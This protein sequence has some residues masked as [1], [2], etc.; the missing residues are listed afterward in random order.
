MYLNT[1]SPID[2]DCIL[3]NFINISLG[4]NIAGNVLIEEN[5]ELVLGVSKKI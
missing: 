3:K 1:K 4:V 2:H 5:V